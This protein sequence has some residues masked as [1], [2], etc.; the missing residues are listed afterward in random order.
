MVGGESGEPVLDAVKVPPA[1]AHRALA[2]KQPRHGI[3]DAEAGL[4]GFELREERL[5]GFA[6]AQSAELQLRLAPQE[7]RAVLRRARRARE[8]VIRDFD[9]LQIHEGLRLRFAFAG[10]PPASFGKHREDDLEET[11]AAHF[12]G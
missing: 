3:G 2:G 11:S 1:E 7:I 10:S 5:D 6:H 9:A 4:A 8:P 12:D